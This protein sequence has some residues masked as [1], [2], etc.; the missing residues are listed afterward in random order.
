MNYFTT[1]SGF[2]YLNSNVGTVDYTT[3]KVILKNIKVSAYSGSDIRIYA[4][5]SNKD[6]TPP[7][8]RII[9]IRPEDVVINVYGV[10]G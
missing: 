10:A 8:N 7:S 9:T 6:I 5:T 3:G 1:T 2:V 4:R